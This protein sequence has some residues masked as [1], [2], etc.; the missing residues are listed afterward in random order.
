[1]ITDILFDFFGT[2]AQYTPGAFRT[3]RYQQTHQF[4]HQRGFPIAYD[5]FVETFTTASNALEAQAKR[6]LHE[7]H[8]H[9]V[10]R[11]IA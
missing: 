11:S 9:D 2:L 8:M 7:Y 1:M 4:L 3:A 10:G 6:T 5:T